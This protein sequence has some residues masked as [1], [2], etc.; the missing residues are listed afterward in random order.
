MGQRTIFSRGIISDTWMPERIPRLLKMPH[1]LL[2]AFSQ[3][4]PAVP[5]LYYH[6]SRNHG[7]FLISITSQH[8]EKPRCP[9]NGINFPKKKKKGTRTDFEAHSAIDQSAQ[10]GATADSYFLLHLYINI[11][12]I[13]LWED[14]SHSRYRRFLVHVL[15][16]CSWLYTESQSESVCCW[17][18]LHLPL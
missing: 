5:G 7:L 16:G 13:D 14:V 15:L 6:E 12:A 4:L 1:S 9:D 10:W 2:S 8:L 3:P 17:F 18:F 11:K